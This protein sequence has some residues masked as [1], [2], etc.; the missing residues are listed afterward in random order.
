MVA[1]SRWQH[2]PGSREIVF[3]LPTPVPPILD[4]DL[5]LPEN[6]EHA[7]RHRVGNPQEWLL[8]RPGRWFHDRDVEITYRRARGAADASAIEIVH[9]SL[10]KTRARPGAGEP[11]RIGA[12]GDS[13]STG[14]DPSETT[15]QPHFHP[16]WGN[17]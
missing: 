14:P 6:A 10:P 17:R 15:G 1:G 2:T 7:Y 12:R 13:I 11:V 8:Y 16:G 5:Y 4:G 3:P 9:G